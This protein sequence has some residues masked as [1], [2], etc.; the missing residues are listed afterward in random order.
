MINLNKLDFSNN[1]EESIEYIEN[2]IDTYGKSFYLE[3]KDFINDINLPYILEALVKKKQSSF[4]LEEMALLECNKEYKPHLQYTSE[5]V[6][7]IIREPNPLLDIANSNQ[8]EILFIN[9]KINDLINLFAEN[10]IIKSDFSD[11][12]ID[13]LQ[14]ASI[15]EYA[16]DLIASNNQF[17]VRPIQSLLE[18][19]GLSKIQDILSKVNE[20]IVFSTRNIQPH[21]VKI[22]VAVVGIG[23]SMFGNTA[24]A[25]D[26]DAMDHLLKVKQEMHNSHAG[27]D[28]KLTSDI[29]HTVSQHFKDY[30]HGS[31]HGTAAVDHNAVHVGDNSVE[32]F[33]IAIKDIHNKSCNINFSVS[34]TGDVTSSIS[35]NDFGDFCKEE[36]RASAKVL[37]HHFSEL[38]KKT[39]K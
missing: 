25:S 31:N 7:S 9:R 22:G 34:S 27:S 14:L 28:H 36:F 11:A 23:L 37:A 24:F 26:S 30:F 17:T 19:T 12:D 33:N 4:L 15:S 32:H 2:L 6:L 21:H 8:G 13:D 29:L 16:C 1:K 3:S 35:K 5:E 18:R 10:K 20:A 39:G 38:A